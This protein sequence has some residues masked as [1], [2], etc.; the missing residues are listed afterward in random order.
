MYKVQAL[1]NLF[2]SK[3]E[4]YKTR[5]TKINS[6]PL[7]A[8]YQN[9]AIQNR[10]IRN[11]SV[12]QKLFRNRTNKHNPKDQCSITTRSIHSRHL[13]VGDPIENSTM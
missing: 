6:N 11:P 1:P 7:T 5:R 3:T 2:F 12:F 10:I 13:N 8:L 4:L 9:R